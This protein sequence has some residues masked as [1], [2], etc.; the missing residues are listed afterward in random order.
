MPSR[1]FSSTVF[2]GN[3]A[4]S[5]NTKAISL[6]RG[7]R[8]G[9]PETSTLPLLGSISPPTTL[10]S[11]LLPQPLGPIRQSSSPRR[12]SSE[13]SASARTYCVSPASP[14]W[15]PTPLMRTATSPAV[16]SAKPCRRETG[17]SAAF[18]RSVLLCCRGEESLG[19]KLAHIR[20]GRQRVQID[21][22]FGQDVETLFI[23][24]AVARE[25]RHYVIVGSA[26]DVRILLQDLSVDCDGLGLVGAHKGDG[27][28]PALDKRPDGVGPGCDQIIGREDHMGDELA[29]VGKA[30]Q[31]AAVAYFDEI[32]GGR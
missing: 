7:P 13:V 24:M 32:V 18:G 17:P 31:N 29:Q 1:T 10:S 4:F 26:N 20:F 21:E 9:C 22:R 28:E 12:M 6:G 25:H 15:W 3:S 14:N 19:V 2:Q 23:E 16:I 11:V 30:H 27:F 8:S 5:W